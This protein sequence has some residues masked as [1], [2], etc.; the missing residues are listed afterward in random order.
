V[1]K[2]IGL[3]RRD[4]EKSIAKSENQKDEMIHHTNQKVKN[5]VN[6]EQNNDEQFHKMNLY[7]SIEQIHSRQSLKRPQMANNKLMKYQVQKD[8]MHKT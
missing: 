7:S 8:A 2:S 3:P 4:D 1:S 6:L 5:S